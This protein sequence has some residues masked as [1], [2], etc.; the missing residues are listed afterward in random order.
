MEILFIQTGGTIDKEY[1]K[2]NKGYAFEITE[3]AAAGILEKVNP[4]FEYEIMP[5][6]RKDSLDIDDE[7]REEIRNACI[8]TNYENIIITH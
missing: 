2:K 6:L 1:P 5:L 8:G 3:P 7:D 4:S